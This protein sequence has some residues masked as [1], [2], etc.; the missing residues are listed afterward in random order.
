MLE[1]PG[2]KMFCTGLLPCRRQYLCQQLV[3]VSHDKEEAPLDDE[4]GN[5]V[6]GKRLLLS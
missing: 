1:K 3:L 5:I 6:E 2:T 4:D